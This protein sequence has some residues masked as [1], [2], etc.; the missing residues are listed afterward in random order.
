MTAKITVRSILT[1]KQHTREIDVDPDLVD[2]F[3]MRL[4]RGTVQDVFPD[5]S[6]EDR[7]FIFTGITPKEWRKYMA[8]LLK[9][10]NQ[11]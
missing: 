7:E 1:G 3:R 5:L 9:K 8:P 2:R 6:A 10:Q 11:T 4:I